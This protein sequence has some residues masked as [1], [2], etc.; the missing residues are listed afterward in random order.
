MTSRKDFNTCL[1]RSLSRSLQEHGYNISATELKM[2][3]L[4]L[5]CL[6]RSLSRSLQ[7][8][9][10]NI[11]ATELKMS[12]ARGERQKTGVIG[13]SID[14]NNFVRIYN[15]SVIIVNS[16]NNTAKD[17]FVSSNWNNGNKS[18]ILIRYSHKHFEPVFQIEDW[19][20]YLYLYLT[21]FK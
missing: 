13:N 19:N 20:C 1:Y 21:L 17:F 8:H 15:I 7:E 10:Y 16:Y 9:G 6:Y 12:I 18:L 11:S 3:I 5:I 14:L 2:S 4:L